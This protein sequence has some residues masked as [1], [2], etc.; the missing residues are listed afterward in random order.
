MR[1]HVLVEITP[2]EVRGRDAQKTAMKGEGVVEKGHKVTRDVN[3]LVAVR[4]DH[5]LQGVLSETIRHTNVII[6]APKG[7][8]AINTTMTV[9]QCTSA[10]TSVPIRHEEMTMMAIWIIG[11]HGRGRCHLPRLRYR[12]VSRPSRH[13]S[14]IVVVIA[15]LRRL[16]PCRTEIFHMVRTS[17]V[18][19]TPKRRYLRNY[20]PPKAAPR[21]PR[22][23]ARD[24]VGW[25]N[26]A[27]T[28]DV[29][30]RPAPLYRVRRQEK[31]RQLAHV[32]P[33]SQRY[34]RSN[35]VR[36]RNPI[37]RIS[38]EVCTTR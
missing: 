35:P 33:V 14:G 13:L 31:I 17:P 21:P 10:K 15:A 8:R 34:P 25:V 16:N 36:H 7:C 24:D 4:R 5:L 2:E 30:G 18:K 32:H 38:R 28:N 3:V 37:C 1:R 23:P 29:P 11:A 12:R 26:P 20:I 6:I 19:P 22:A 9:K 27:P